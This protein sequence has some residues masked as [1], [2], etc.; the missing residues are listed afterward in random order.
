M[1]KI[2]NNLPLEGE[3]SFL[4]IASTSAQN[5]AA[6]TS[7][8]ST[9]GSTT[10]GR[11]SK[12]K[13]IFVKNNAEE[14]RITSTAVPNSQIILNPSNFISNNTA[15]VFDGTFLTTLPAGQEHLALNTIGSNLETNSASSSNVSLQQPLVSD[16]VTILSNFTEII[17]ASTS[18]QATTSQ[19]FLIK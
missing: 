2:R 15:A 10:K 11:G 9:T 18:Q 1:E 4:N 12:G 13:N 16:Q 17:R 8:A 6:S 14:N 19:V 3:S 5:N 7:K